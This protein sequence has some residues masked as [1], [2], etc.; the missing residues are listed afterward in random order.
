[1]ACN[2]GGMPILR[3]LPRCSTDTNFGRGNIEHL[4]SHRHRNIAL[5]LRDSFVDRATLPYDSS[6]HN[7][8]Y[9]DHD[10]CGHLSSPLASLETFGLGQLPQF[11]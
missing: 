8:C 2:Y 1:M 11:L 4:C 9:G 6:V 10:A 5:I 3:D 7:P